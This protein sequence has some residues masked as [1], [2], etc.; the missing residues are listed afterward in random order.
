MK[1]V[2]NIMLGNEVEL[3]EQHIQYHLAIGIEAFVIVDMFSRDGT[4]RKLERYR[5]DPRFKIRDVTPEEVIDESRLKTPELSSWMLEVARTEFQADWVI[6]LDADEFIFPRNGDLAASIAELDEYS[7]LQIERRNVVFPSG[8]TSV[9]PPVS[10]QALSKY[11]V[12]AKPYQST[13]DSYGNDPNLPLNLTRV[14]PKTIVKA[15]S[16]YG[17]GNGA[18]MAL[19]QHGKSLAAAPAESIISIQ[20]WFTTYSRFAHKVEFIHSFESSIN[21]QHRKNEGWQWSRWSKLFAQGEDAVTTEFNWQFPKQAQ[22]KELMDQGIIS[23]V[24]KY[25][26]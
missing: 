3:I 25:W 6:R 26:D 7:A 9:N 16:A 20:F 18:H 22:F 21:K 2:A 15:D 19:D 24:G 13:P 5:S 4:I 11:T 23:T 10:W 1:I 8:S 17:F 14:C 12:V